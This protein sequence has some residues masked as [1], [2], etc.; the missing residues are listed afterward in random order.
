MLIM[1]FHKL[2][3]S[4]I[5]WIIFS[6][7][8]VVSFV[9][10]Q[11]S[12]DSAP[13]PA[14]ARLNQPVA[15]IAGNDVSFLKFDLTRRLISMQTPSRVD[16]D[17]LENL[18]FNHLAMV[19]YAESVGIE[20]DTEFATL[21]F[22]S[23]FTDE[24]GN[25]DAEA[26]NRFRVQ[27]QGTQLSET[28]YIEF[29]R[30]QLVI[31]QLRRA[32]FGAVVVPDF[33][34]ERWADL[35]T[36]KFVVSYAPVGPEIL[37]GPVVAD[38][39]TVAAYFEEN[40]EDFPLP[41]QRV[42]RYTVLPDAI[43]RSSVEQPTT[44]E[45]RERYEANSEQYTRTVDVPPETEGDEVTQKEEPIPFEEVENA[46]IAELVQERAMAAAE[47][48]ALNM[49]IRLTPR[50][51]RAPESLEALAK[52]QG[53]ALVTTPAFSMRDQLEGVVNTFPFK[54]AAFEIAG[55]E[56]SSIAGPVQVTGGSAIMELIE[57]IPPKE[58]ELSDVQDQVQRVVNRIETQKAV[59]TAAEALQ[60][61]LATAVA[62]GTSFSDAAKAKNLNPLTSEPVSFIDLNPR[63]PSVPLEIFEA[64]T[65]T[66]PGEVV[67]PIE[68]RFGRSFI[69]SVDSRTSQPL[70]KEKALPEVRS[71]L[72]NQVQFQGTFQ[73][74]QETVIE[75]LIEKL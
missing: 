72:T 40:K 65:G 24:Q 9:A 44:E 6:F 3:Q 31:D 14:L 4:R 25:I 30:E 29:I 39:E 55:G 56:F 5:V 49:L 60:E 18:T 47:Q 45:A 61:E 41:E 68:S 64:I 74:F 1:R 58:A 70:A 71:M 16:A 52:E 54:R 21:E 28:D 38:A 48:E 26:L 62:G 50:R 32:M 8:I 19:A 63:N 15:R 35:Q 75:P 43:F 17:L 73:R 59:Q 33:D 12:S 27:I 66:S 23:G 13:D 67:G 51:G 37:E 7:I 2:I 20:V 46:L 42:V 22:A 34:V 69:A 10:L 36:A 57:I 53:I 11:V